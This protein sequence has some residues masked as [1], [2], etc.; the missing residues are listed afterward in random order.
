MNTVGD[1]PAS[2]VLVLRDAGLGSP[3]PTLFLA[4]T[5]NS[6]STHAFRST[7]V[8]VKVLPSITSGTEQ[9]EKPRFNRKD[10]DYTAPKS[11]QQE[12]NFEPMFTVSQKCHET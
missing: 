5:L 4:S 8:A 7:T 12:P 6:Y 3:T 11:Q 9:T 1:S 10:L 2:S